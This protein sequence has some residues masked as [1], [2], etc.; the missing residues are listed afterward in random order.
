[1]STRSSF[2]SHFAINWQ[3]TIDNAP[4]KDKEENSLRRQCHFSTLSQNVNAGNC[5]FLYFV[6]HTRCCLLLC[7]EPEEFSNENWV[8]ITG[9]CLKK[10][11]SE[12]IGFSGFQNDHS[13]H[14]RVLLCRFL[15][16]QRSRLPR[17]C[18][19]Q[20]CFNG[21]RC[22]LSYV[23]TQTEISKTTTGEQ[24]RSKK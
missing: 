19:C 12:E 22:A 13:D 15:S 9:E 24:R 18:Y 11:F 6:A 3:Q 4:R 8:V 23:F 17:R 14:P 2:L 1:M 20:F 5:T 10:S 16:Q 7:G 21:P